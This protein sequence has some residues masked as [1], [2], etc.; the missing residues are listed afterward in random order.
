MLN[1]TSSTKHGSCTHTSRGLLL[2]SPFPFWLLFS[3]VLLVYN[4]LGSAIPDNHCDM[5][6]TYS[7]LSLAA[8]ITVL[9]AILSLRLMAEHVQRGAR[10]TPNVDLEGFLSAPGQAARRIFVYL[11]TGSR[12]LILMDSRLKDHIYCG[13]WDRIP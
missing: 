2:G 7:F 13:F 12:Y 9:M 8:I 4:F 11:P 10:T 1:D 6:R 5:Y 3:R